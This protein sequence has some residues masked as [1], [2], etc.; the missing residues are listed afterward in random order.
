MCGRLS[1]KSLL[2]TA[3]SEPTCRQDTYISRVCY[4]KATCV[5]SAMFNYGK[6][7]PNFGVPYAE[8]LLLGLQFGEGRG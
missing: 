5:I 2:S 3:R 6:L 7:W 1:L 4:T 8:R